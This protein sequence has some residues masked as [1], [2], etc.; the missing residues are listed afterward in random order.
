MVSD[1]AA[2]VILEWNKLD[3]DMD[4]STSTNS[5]KKCLLQF[6]RLSPSSLFNGHSPKGTKFEQSLRLGLSHL[7]EQKFK[8]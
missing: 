5:F 1:L 7:Q 8:L 2:S 6:V 3:I 4:N